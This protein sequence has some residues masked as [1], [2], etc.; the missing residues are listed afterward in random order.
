MLSLVISRRWKEEILC[1]PEL[2]LISQNHLAEVAKLRWMMVHMVGFLSN[3]SGCRI[4]V[5]SVGVSHIMTKTDL[6]LDSEGTMSNES[7]KYGAWMRAPLFSPAKKSTVVVPGYYKKRK[8]VDHKTG[9]AAPPPARQTPESAKTPAPPTQKVTPDP[10]PILNEN[11][12]S[13]KES[14]DCDDVPPGFEGQQTVKGKVAQQLHEIDTELNKFKDMEGVVNILV[15][16]PYQDYSGSKSLNSF[17]QQIFAASL[18]DENPGL[19]KP[20][21]STTLNHQESPTLITQP[22][23]AKWTCMPR[24]ETRILEKLKVHAGEK[25]WF[26]TMVRGTFRKWQWLVPNPVKSHESTMLEL[27]GVWELADSS[28]A[29]GHSPDLR[30]YS[31]VY[32]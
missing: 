18:I 27:S 30:S 20:S 23:V 26:L 6:W 22:A 24:I 10:T 19:S 4:F 15:V 25:R 11:M 3:L 28:R 17:D 12:F 21:L 5:V 7:R 14:R 13:G 31:C 32:S 2:L 16:I 1:E 29:W 8:T 9:S